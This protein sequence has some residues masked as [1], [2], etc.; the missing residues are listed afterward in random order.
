[1]NKRKLERHNTRSLQKQ[2]AKNL[3][4]SEMWIV[5]RLDDE[6]AH[7]HMPNQNHMALFG[8]FFKNQPEILEMVNQ[9]VNGD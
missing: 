6:G 5:L 2:M 8:V 4:K 7:L 1:M 9:F 3:S